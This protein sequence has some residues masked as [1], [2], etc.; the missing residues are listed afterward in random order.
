MN[1]IRQIAGQLFD[2]LKSLFLN[3]IL[4]ILPLAITVFLLKAVFGFVKSWLYPLKKFEPAL[5]KTI[6]HDEIVLAALIILGIGFLSKNFL[7]KKFM[8]SFEELIKKIPLIGTVYTGVKQLGHALTNQDKLSFNQ[9]V[10]AE[11][12]NKGSY[13][14]GFLTGECPAQMSPDTTQPYLNVYIPTTPNP[15]TGFFIL[16]PAEKVIMTPLTRQEAM[17]LIIS[18]GIIQPERFKQTT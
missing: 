2:K 4:F 14:V 3:G 6:P 18:G 7:L 15:T 5:F 16:M 12:P 11:F 9:V 1:R 10:L 8:H 17:T 13:C